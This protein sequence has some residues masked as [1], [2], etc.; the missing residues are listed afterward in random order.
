M[1]IVVLLVL[2]LS[3]FKLDMCYY[4]F[5]QACHVCL[6]LSAYVGVHAV[7][8]DLWLWGLTVYIYSLMT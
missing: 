4:L 3:Y 7:H 6:M 2:V 8:S 1:T 5:Q